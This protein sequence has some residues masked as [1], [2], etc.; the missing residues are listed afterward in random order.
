MGPWAGW[1]I[2]AAHPRPAPGASGIQASKELQPV[3][4][5]GYAWWSVCVCGCVTDS[6]AK[7]VSHLVE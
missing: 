6:H 7:L 1:H 4:E 5:T 3:G 2:E